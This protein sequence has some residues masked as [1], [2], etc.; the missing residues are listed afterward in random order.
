MTEDYHTLMIMAIAGCAV[1]I[2]IHVFTI[3]NMAFLTNIIPM[4]LFILILYLYLKCSRYLKD[5]LRENNETSIV[6]L[7]TSRIPVWL[8]W[9]VYAFGLY[10]IFNFLIFYIHNNKPGYIDFNVSVIK[11]RLVSGILTALFFAAIALIYA[12]K[13]I[14]RK[15]DEL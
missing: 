11:L 1:S 12:I 6:Y 7:I 13:D 10:A 3:F 9:L 14:N 15:K 2:I 4:L 8:K 5:I